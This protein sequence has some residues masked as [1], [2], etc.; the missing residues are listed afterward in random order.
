M[1]K[2]IFSTNAAKQ[3]INSVDFAKA[4]LIPAIAIDFVSNEVLMQAWI[5][6]EALFETLT[7]GQVCYYSRSKNALWRKGETS[8]HVQH[9]HSVRLDCDNDC[10]MFLVEQLGA[11][12]H[13]F[14]RNCFFQQATK[15]G[16]WQ[17]ISNPIL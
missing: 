10:I 8:G 12:C 9:L 11:A 3:L 4:E 7:T 16:D 2:L 13:T 14:R 17:I 15:E 1:N 5:N 6:K